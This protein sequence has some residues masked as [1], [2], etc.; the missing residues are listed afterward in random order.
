MKT[1]FLAQ[2]WKQSRDNEDE[3]K[4]VL[5]TDAQQIDKVMA[6]PTQKILKVVVEW[7]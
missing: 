7:E 2:L 3:I 6:L 4:L 5:L 1:E